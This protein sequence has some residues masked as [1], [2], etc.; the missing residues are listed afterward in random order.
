M[1]V[2]DF[3]SIATHGFMATYSRLSTFLQLNSCFCAV[4]VVVA[5]AVVYYVLVDVKSY[6]ALFIM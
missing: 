2:K 1:R 3:I 6:I 4:K 5:V